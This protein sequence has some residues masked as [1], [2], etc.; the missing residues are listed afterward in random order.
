MGTWPEHFVPDDIQ[1]G[2]NW[3]YNLT[4][5]MYKYY[6]GLYKKKKYRDEL[7]AISKMYEN[8]ETDLILNE[9]TW[10][11]MSGLPQL[12]QKLYDKLIEIQSKRN[13]ILKK[14]KKK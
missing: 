1:F 13:A 9:K 5:I 14:I 3:H 6:R 11:T 10:D 12:T 7:L 4:Y 8:W 2:A